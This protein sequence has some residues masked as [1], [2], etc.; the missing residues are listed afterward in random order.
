MYRILPFI[1]AIM[2]ILTGCADEPEIS[3]I[4][5]KEELEQFI[6]D[7]KEGKESK[8]TITFNVVGTFSD[9]D[10][11]DEVPNDKPE[12]VIVYHLTSKYDEKAK[13]RWIEVEPELSDFKQSQ[14]NPITVVEDRQQCGSITKDEESRY[15]MLTECFHRWEY[16][17]IS[18]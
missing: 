1:V 13:E 3:N 12:G 2:M 7:F 14:D 17:L 16:K 9:R 4:S 10:P 6:K 18:L 11:F 8:V 5:Q 15:Y